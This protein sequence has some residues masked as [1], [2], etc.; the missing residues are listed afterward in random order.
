MDLS[1]TLLVIAPDMRHAWAHISTDIDVDPDL[2][3]RFVRTE[4]D[5]RGYSPANAE[6]VYCSRAGYRQDWPKLQRELEARGFTPANC[7]EVPCAPLSA[8]GTDDA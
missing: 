5:L 6:V 2:G 8:S 3:W 4:R 7:R 1:R